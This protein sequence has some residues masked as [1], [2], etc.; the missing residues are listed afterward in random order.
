[1][2]DEALKRA[3]ARACL[4]TDPS[5]KSSSFFCLFQRRL[6]KKLKELGLDSDIKIRKAVV[7]PWVQEFLY[8]VYRLGLTVSE[9]KE[10]TQNLKILDFL[11]SEKVPEYLKSNFPK[12][13]TGVRSGENSFFV[14]NGKFPKRGGRY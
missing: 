6:K 12:K 7:S 5:I 13:Y 10:K 9:E 1:M 2:S 3:Q 4:L 8:S 11:F 14:F